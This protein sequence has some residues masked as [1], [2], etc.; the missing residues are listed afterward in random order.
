MYKENADR[1]GL[2]YKETH[3]H[4][5]N[6][7]VVEVR[8]Y[9]DLNCYVGYARVAVL[10]TAMTGIEWLDVEAHSDTSQGRSCDRYLAMRLNDS[11]FAAGV[12]ASEIAEELAREEES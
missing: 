9:R 8:I 6:E 7:V 4:S 3:V 5:L 12:Y 1:A 2:V 10:H 11:R